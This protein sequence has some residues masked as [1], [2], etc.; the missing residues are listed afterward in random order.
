MSDKLTHKWLTE[1]GFSQ[2]PGHPVRLIKYVDSPQAHLMG[3]HGISAYFSAQLDR[4]YWALELHR[5]DLH[6]DDKV[7][8]LPHGCQPQTEA[9]AEYLIAALEGLWNDL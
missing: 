7:M 6:W 3:Q 9:S 1:H 5:D 8:P 4:W 2:A